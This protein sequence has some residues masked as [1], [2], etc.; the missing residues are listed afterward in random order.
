[1]YSFIVIRTDDNNGKSDYDGKTGY[2]R[3]RRGGLTS[4]GGLAL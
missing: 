2:G 1:M 3:G 4:K